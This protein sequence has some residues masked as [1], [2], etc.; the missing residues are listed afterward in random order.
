MEGHLRRARKPDEHVLLRH[1][2][3]ALPAQG[4]V[5]RSE[6]ALSTSGETGRACPTSAADGKPCLSKDGY[7]RWKTTFD[8]R[9]NKTSVSYFGTDGKPCLS[10]DGVAGWNNHFDERGN[11]TSS[12][13][14]RR[15]RQALPDQ[16]RV[17]RT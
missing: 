14:L 6:G 10:K 5:C 9:G 13:L 16:G 17:R 1:R 2:R 7:A 15:R 11:Q 8:E 12:V 4:R 3:Q